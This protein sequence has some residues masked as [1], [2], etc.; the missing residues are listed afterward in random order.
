[1]LSGFQ[2][3][4]LGRTEAR[5]R[6]RLARAI[7]TYA[8]LDAESQESFAAPYRRIGWPLFSWVLLRMGIDRPYFVVGGPLMAVV[9]YLLVVFRLIY[10]WTH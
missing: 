7:T 6:R 10:F 1:M 4:V 2:R 5:Y 8:N 3:A 9:L